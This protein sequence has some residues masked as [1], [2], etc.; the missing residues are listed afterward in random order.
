M[1]EM[2]TGTSMPVILILKYV[3]GVVEDD[4]RTKNLG[5]ASQLITNLSFE[6][7]KS[8]NED[9][10]LLADKHQL[11]KVSIGFNAILQMIIGSGHFIV[12]HADR[13]KDE[14]A[15]Q[16]FAR[17]LK[18]PYARFLSKLIGLALTTNPVALTSLSNS[19]IYPTCLCSGW[20]LNLEWPPFV[21]PLT[22]YNSFSDIP[23]ST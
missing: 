3:Y 11:F 1:Y 12:N 9:P 16:A 22:P 21:Y 23:F 15:I 4:G 2:P 6:V 13:S 20:S 10:S 8:I 5:T 7:N 14:F 17:I 18:S 19:G